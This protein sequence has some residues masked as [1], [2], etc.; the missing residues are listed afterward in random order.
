[1]DSEPNE[2]LVSII[3][4]TAK[5]ETGDSWDARTG[6]GEQ[7]L[8]TGRFGQQRIIQ[9]DKTGHIFPPRSVVD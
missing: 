4:G 7:Q 3:W 1:M 2:M 9:R 8:E 5:S 6:L